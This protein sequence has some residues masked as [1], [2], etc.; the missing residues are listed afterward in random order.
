MSGPVYIRN[1]GRFSVIPP[2]DSYTVLT[3]SLATARTS[4][5]TA[6]GASGTSLVVASLTGTAQIRLNSTS[7]PAIIL[8]GGETYIGDF[9]E[10]Y[11][12]NAA[13]P[14]GSVVLWI[15]KKTN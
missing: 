5:G 8:R 2:E 14:I 1:D 15:G 7:S 4:P 12:T 10:V 9:T 13:Q 3:V 11:L 6:L